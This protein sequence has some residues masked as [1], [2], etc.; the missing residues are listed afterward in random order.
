MLHSSITFPFYPDLGKNC[1]LGTKNANLDLG[2]VF[3]NFGFGLRE[4]VGSLDSGGGGGY[5]ATL[6]LD[7][8]K[9]LEVWISGGYSAT[10]DLDLGKKL[11]VW[12]SGGGG[13]SATSDLDLGKKLEVWISGGVFCN[14]GFRLREKVGSLDSGG[15]VFCNFGF[16]LREKVGSLDSGGGYSAT[17]DLDLGKKL[18]VWILGGYSATS[19]LD[20]GKK[21]EVWISGGGILQLQIWT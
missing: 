12:I 5:S 6:D 15:G 2:G 3:C 11:E 13:Y 18:E 20:L 16:G 17:S 8:G 7:L 21:L 14:F 4:K 10:S 19:D 1:D 9:K